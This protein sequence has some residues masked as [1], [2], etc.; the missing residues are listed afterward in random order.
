MKHIILTC[1]IVVYTQY[2][3][4]KISHVDGYAKKNGTYVLPHQKTSPNKTKFDNWSHKRNM[5]PYTSKK[6]TKN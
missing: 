5:N 2:A 3:F 1:S 4:A 6:G